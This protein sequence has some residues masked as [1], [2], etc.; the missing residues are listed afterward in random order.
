MGEQQR[1]T[2]RF[3]D[4]SEVQYLRKI[5][6]IGDYVSHQN[7]LWTVSSIEDDGLGA[8]ITCEPTRANTTSD[9]HTRRGTL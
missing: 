4:D 5:P 1:V 9:E 8:H 6:A 3:G 7:A 2:F